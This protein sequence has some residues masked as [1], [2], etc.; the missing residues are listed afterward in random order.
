MVDALS[1][2]MIC[3]EILTIEITSVLASFRIDA[4][5]FVFADWE[6][7]WNLS[8]LKMPFPT[9]DFLRLVETHAPEIL[10]RVFPFNALLMV[11]DEWD[12]R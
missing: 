2:K 11:Q 6:V 7:I 8:D 4:R 1:Y 10:I 5:I 3:A 12:K 9:V